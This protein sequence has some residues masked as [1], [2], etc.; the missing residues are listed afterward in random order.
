MDSSLRHQVAE[1]E[2]ELGANHRPDLVRGSPLSPST[3]PTWVNLHITL[4]LHHLT[5]P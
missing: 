2:G 1:K 4:T 3:P 5:L